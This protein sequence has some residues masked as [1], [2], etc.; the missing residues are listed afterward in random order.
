MTGPLEVPPL[1]NP[2]FSSLRGPHARFAERKGRALRYPVVPVL[3][4]RNCPEA[5][6]FVP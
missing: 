1:D 4:R 5:G 6:M 2:V 3:C